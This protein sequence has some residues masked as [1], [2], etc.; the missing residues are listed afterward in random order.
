M[1]TFYTVAKSIVAPVVRAAWAPRV[2]GLEN[3]PRSGG[4]ILASNH[5]ANVDSFLIPVVIPRGIRF[6][7]KDDF[8]KRKGPT[9]LIMRLFFDGI[10]TVPLDRAA[11]SSGKHALQA[12]L[13]ILR[14]GDGF[15]IYPEG[16]RSK[17]GLLRPGKPGAAWLALE[18]GCPVIPVG[19]IGTPLLFGKGRRLPLGL[20]ARGKIEVHVGEPLRADDLDPALST[21]ARRRELTRVLMERIQGLTGQELAPPRAASGADAPA[22]S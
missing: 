1:T 13:G 6:V 14:D 21:G 17:D 3:I 18:S 19:L 22:A 20:S 8:W 10:G 11:L 4:F 12:A 15:A 16:A 7:S 2:T 9:G 5:L